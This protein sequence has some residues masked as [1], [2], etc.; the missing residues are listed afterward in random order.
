MAW[1]R[2]EASVGVNHVPAR[3]SA[4]KSVGCTA[5]GAQYTASALACQILPLIRLGQ[6]AQALDAPVG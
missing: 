6:G 2:Q 5:R 1:P 3:T 4:G